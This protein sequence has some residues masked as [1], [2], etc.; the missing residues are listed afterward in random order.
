MDRLLGRT[1]DVLFRRDG[2]RIGRLDGVFKS[3]L[4]VIEA[5]VIQES[6]DRILVR[7]V[8]SDGFSEEAR[9]TLERRLRKKLGD[10]E[11]DFEL[12]NEIPRGRNGKYRQFVCKLANRNGQAERFDNV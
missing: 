10:P 4:G 5:Q 9:R 1:D 8:P 3:D 12:C 7:V 6:V 11:I 2:R